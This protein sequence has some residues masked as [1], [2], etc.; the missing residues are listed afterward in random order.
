MRLCGERFYVRVLRE[1]RYVLIALAPRYAATPA[2]SAMALAPCRISSLSMLDY[3]TFPLPS[4]LG[5]APNLAPAVAALD[6]DYVP[7]G[8]FF[9]TVLLESFAWRIC[10]GR[11]A[12]GGKESMFRV[13][14]QM[15]TVLETLADLDAAQ[16]TAPSKLDL[17]RKLAD[18]GGCSWQ[19]AYAAIVRCQRAGLVVLD[20]THP[21]SSSFG[22]GAVRLS[23]RGRRTLS[24]RPKVA[25]GT[26]V[27]G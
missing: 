19:S 3:A 14:P 13:G 27:D 24:E 9:L 20:P 2:R 10:W 1:T 8:G 17:A 5:R 15:L 22:R 4:V 18:E 11:Y 23:E 6:A 25:I 26:P 12:L 7:A 16:V 21:E